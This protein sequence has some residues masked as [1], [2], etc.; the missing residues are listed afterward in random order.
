MQKWLHPSLALTVVAA[1]DSDGDLFGKVASDLQ[2]NIT[3]NEG[4]ISGTLKYISDYS[5]AG[6]TGDEKSGN[7]L[8]LKFTPVTGATTTVEVLGG[9]HGASTLD[10]DGLIVC[11]I[12]NT[13]QQIKVVTTKNSQSSTYIYSLAGLVLQNA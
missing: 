12:M 1:E 4:V 10:A 9:L 13:N 11:R 3:I 5:A 6:F 7:F 2:S 8:A